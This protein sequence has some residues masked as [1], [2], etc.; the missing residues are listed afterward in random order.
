MSF[1][2]CARLGCMLLLFACVFHLLPRAAVAMQKSM[3]SAGG[4]ADGGDGGGHDDR[5]R[6]IGDDDHDGD[7]PDEDDHDGDEP[8]EDD[9]HLEP[10]QQ[11]RRWR[12]HRRVRPKTEGAPS[13]KK[14]DD[15]HDGDEPDEDDHDCTCFYCGR[16]RTQCAW[17]GLGTR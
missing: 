12:L 9:H 8:D 10:P 16:S 13:P 15:D 1:H 2:V 11:K 14:G 17:A 4:G 3:S 5:K 7:E 6:A